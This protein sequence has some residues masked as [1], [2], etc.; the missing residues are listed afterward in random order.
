MHETM[1]SVTSVRLFWRWPSEEDG[2]AAPRPWA[3]AWR[4]SAQRQ[5]NIKHL[6]SLVLQPLAP[7]PLLLAQRPNVIDDL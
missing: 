4:P 5:T 2:A 1:A 6:Q 3:S 7:A